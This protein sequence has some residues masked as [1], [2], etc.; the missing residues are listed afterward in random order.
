MEQTKASDGTLKG[1]R[2]RQELEATS[3]IINNVSENTSK[4]QRRVNYNSVSKNRSNISHPLVPPPPPPTEKANLLKS[5]NYTLRQDNIGE[6]SPCEPSL[7]TSKKTS[8]NTAFIK[9]GQECS[10]KDIKSVS[11]PIQPHQ[12]HLSNSQYVIS[13]SSTSSSI[14]KSPPSFGFEG[15]SKDDYKH[16]ISTT[17]FKDDKGRLLNNELLSSDVLL[18]GSVYIHICPSHV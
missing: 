9:I 16:A 18:S 17:S 13:S 7:E 3:K 12:R 15:I 2:C 10:Q 8:N 1:F 6:M 11:L 5:I 14:V 4:S